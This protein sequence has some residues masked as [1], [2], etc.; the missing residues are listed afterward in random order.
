MDKGACF[1]HSVPQCISFQ[2]E[3][4]W[5]WIKANYYNQIHIECNRSQGILNVRMALTVQSSPGPDAVVVRVWCARAQPKNCPCR[6][7]FVTKIKREAGL[8]RS[9]SATHFQSLVQS[10]RGHVR[11]LLAEA[12]WFL[13]LLWRSHLIVGFCFWFRKVRPANNLCL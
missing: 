5:G 7:W 10:A 4:T 11:L 2:Q 12:R 3:W 1:S 6:T 9:V 8:N 13:A